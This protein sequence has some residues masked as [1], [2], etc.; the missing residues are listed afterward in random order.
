[1][2]QALGIIGFFLSLLAIYIAAES[3][4]RAGERQTKLQTEVFKASFRIQELEERVLR[5]DRLAKGAE[6]QKKR[7]AGTLTAMA[8]KGAVQEEHT[9]RLGNA[10]G[11]FTPSQNFSKKTG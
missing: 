11:R 8:E 4:R 1:M 2:V 10:K 9:Q 3:V 6:Q 7:Q 5:L